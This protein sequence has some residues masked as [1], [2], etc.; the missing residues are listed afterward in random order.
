MGWGCWEPSYSEPCSPMRPSTSLVPHQPASQNHAQKF[1]IS[2]SAFKPAT[3]MGLH[4]LWNVLLWVSEPPSSHSSSLPQGLGCSAFSLHAVIQ[5]NM[6]I[7]LHWSWWG[8][9]RQASQESGFFL[10][11]SEKQKPATQHSQSQFSSKH[12]PQTGA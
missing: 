1:P 2:L 4:P 8:P 7:V 5:K 6:C 11:P 12:L 9:G 10:H 3:Q